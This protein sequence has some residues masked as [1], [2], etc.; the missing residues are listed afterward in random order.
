MAGIRPLAFALSVLGALA[1][2]GLTTPTRAESTVTIA[3]A[4]NSLG[5]LPIFIARQ[6][7]FFHDAGIAI[8]I[9]DF[10]GGAPAVQAL[11]SGSVDLCLCAADHAIRLRNHGQRAVVLAALADY[12]PYGL[13]ALASS[14]ATD[15]T[16]LKGKRLGITS[17]G[18]LT[19]NTIRY[20]IGKLKLDPDTDFQIISVGTGGPMRAAIDTGAVAA[21]LLTTPDVQ[22]ALASGKYKL[23]ED[24][25]T[26]RYPSLDVM[27]IQSWIDGHRDLARDT[28]QAVVHA[29]QL[30]Q[31]GDPAVAAALTEM[32]P[33][34]DPTLRADLARDAKL[35]IAA[36]GRMA[37]EGYDRMVDMLKASEP[38]LRAVPYAEIAAPQQPAGK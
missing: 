37:P 33:Q 11:A 22:A 18:S 5:S 27:A 2:A 32:F 25:R 4:Q 21:G 1:T 15:L 3:S 35:T 26:L 20:V 30:I 24:Y 10:K 6:K 16:S 29:E 23:V 31:S 12:H 19:D 8:Q 38:D 28:T 34:L 7:G 17:A 14:S 9:V 13:V 36:D